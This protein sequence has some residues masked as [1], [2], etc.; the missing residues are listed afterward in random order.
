MTIKRYFL[1]GFILSNDVILIIT[2]SLKIVLAKILF[3]KATSQIESCCL[4]GSA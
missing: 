4:F 1:L 2:D 3:G